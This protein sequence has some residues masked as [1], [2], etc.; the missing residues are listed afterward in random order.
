MHVYKWRK[1]T[2]ESNQ[3]HPCCVVGALHDHLEEIFLQPAGH[4]PMTPA[5]THPQ[6]RIQITY[7]LLS[8]LHSV[9]CDL[10]TELK[11]RRCAS[12]AC[13]LQYY[14]EKQKDRGMNQSPCMDFYLPASGG[15]A[16]G[17]STADMPIIC[18]N[19]TCSQALHL[20]KN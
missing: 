7:M 3:L 19:G 15:T 20:C 1:K 13:R 18:E 2:T 12:L 14:L 11:A 9:Y 17:V 6:P 10:M 16:K 5:L 8:S 4:F